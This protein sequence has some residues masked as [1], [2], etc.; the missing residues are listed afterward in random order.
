MQAA[1]APRTAIAAIAAW[2]L[3]LMML[4]VLLLLVAGRAT[5]TDTAAAMKEMRMMVV[6]GI[7]VGMLMVLVSHGVYVH[8]GRSGRRQRRVR[9]VVRRHLR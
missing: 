1:H 3:L 5:A 6:G 9:F 2:R 7:E 4:Q 8:G